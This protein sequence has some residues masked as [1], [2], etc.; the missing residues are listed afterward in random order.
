[1]PIQ[2]LSDFM[3][4]FNISDI[5]NIFKRIAGIMKEDLDPVQRLLNI[6]EAVAEFYDPVPNH[7]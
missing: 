7:G 3:R 1:M 6:F 2:A 4:Q 5:V